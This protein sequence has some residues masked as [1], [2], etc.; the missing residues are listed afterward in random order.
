MISVDV[1]DVVVPV[2]SAKPS[3]QP[4]DSSAAAVAVAVV[5]VGVAVNPTLLGLANTMAEADLPLSSDWG[6]SQG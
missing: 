3:S 6:K 1:V 4:E 2:S 5:G